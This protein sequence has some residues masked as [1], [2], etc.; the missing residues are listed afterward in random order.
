MRFHCSRTIAVT[1]SLVLCGLGAAGCSLAPSILVSQ[2]PPGGAAMSLT[3]DTVPPGAQARI[4]DGVSCRTPCELTVT[5][6]G[7]FMVD[8]TLKN[9]E[10]RSVEVVLAPSDSAEPSAGIR[11]EPNPLVVT[12]TATPR[13]ISPP[14]TRPVAKQSAAPIAKQ[15]EPPVAKQSAPK[16]TWPETVGTIWPE[17]PSR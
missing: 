17:F 1:V 11:L 5:P 13:P 7:P 9:Y 16:A 6:M 14:G 8:F 10:P 12:L 3:V 2:S 4:R 15:S